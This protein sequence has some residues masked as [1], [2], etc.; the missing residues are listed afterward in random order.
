MFQLPP[1]VEALRCMAIERLWDGDHRR[2]V[3]PHLMELI[4]GYCQ[5]PTISLDCPREQIL[6]DKSWTSSPFIFND[7]G[8]LY[9]VGREQDNKLTLQSIRLGM[10]SAQ[11]AFKSVLCSDADNEEWKCYYDNSNRMLF[12]LYNH[13]AALMKY[14]ME[15]NKLEAS[16][17]IPF[18]DSCGPQVQSILVIDDNLYVCTTERGF[19]GRLTCS[20]FVLFFIKLTK[21]DQVRLVFDGVM[22][23][24]S[25]VRLAI[26][27][28]QPRAIRLYYRE[29]EFWRRVK[30]EMVR[31]DNPALFT[32]QC[33]EEFDSRK[34][35]GSIIQPVGLDMLLLVHGGKFEFRD[36]TS[37]I[38]MGELHQCGISWKESLVFDRW[39]ISF[40]NGSVGGYPC[41]KCYHPYIG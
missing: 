18:L 32:Q 41:T 37:F 40:I 39:T 31:E 1:H 26:V 14:N 28:G 12:I 23:A 38:K 30:V 5:K 20:T 16:I 7:N 9:G 2:E 29:G 15:T 13:G 17:K 10:Y 35:E 34:I 27:S 6:T 22:E 33:D 3:M 24:Y 21:P 36:P 11:L 19:N 8:I 4:M 25:P